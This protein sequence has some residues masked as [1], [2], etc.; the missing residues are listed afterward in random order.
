M[1]TIFNINLGSAVYCGDWL[2]IDETLYP[3]KHNVSFR[4]ISFSYRHRYGTVGTPTEQHPTKRH[5]DKTSPGQNITRT[6]QQP[7]QNVIKDKRH[8]I[9]NKL[10]MKITYY[11]ILG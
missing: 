6:K 8:K 4:W 7:R 9:R 3:M 11:I 5:S 1:L 10:A 2:S